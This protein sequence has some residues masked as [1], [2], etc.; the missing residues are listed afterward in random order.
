V[1]KELKQE[2]FD[3]I[4]EVYADLLEIKTRDL[5]VNSPFDIVITQAE[6]ADEI[7]TRYGFKENQVMA[8]LEKYKMREFGNIQA[9]IRRLN[10]ATRVLMQPLGH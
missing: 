6:A 10:A 2:V 7:Y 5:V 8:A 9:N 1:P 4:I 3:E